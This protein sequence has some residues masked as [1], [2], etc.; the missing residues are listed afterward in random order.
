MSIR[1]QQAYSLEEQFSSRES[2]EL[3][4]YLIIKTGTNGRITTQLR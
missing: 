2:P 3:T 4:G 1:K